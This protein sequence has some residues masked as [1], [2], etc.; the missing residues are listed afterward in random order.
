MKP[1]SYDSFVQ[2]AK[3]LANKGEEYRLRLMHLLVEMEA[4]KIVWYGHPHTTW[5]DV[6]REER[7]CTPAAFAAFKKAATYG[8]KV[9]KLGVAA[10]CLLAK[11]TKAV[12][13]IVVKQATDWVK[14]HHVPP[15]YQLVSE[16]VK[17]LLKDRNKQVISPYAKVKAERDRL[18]AENN[19]LTGYV[20]TL[21]NTLRLNGIPIPK[22]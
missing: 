21:R 14:T 1:K 12:R 4:Q 22:R 3:N 16:Y 11:Q 15:S 8:L 17:H 19:R 7:L 6:L 18:Q 10:S 20:T 2:T 5:G 9:D 13:T